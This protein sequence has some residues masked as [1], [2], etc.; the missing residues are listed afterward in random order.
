MG[1]CWRLFIVGCATYSVE[2]RQRSQSVLD[3]DIVLA[4][5]KRYISK[6]DAL[7]TEQSLSLQGSDIQDDVDQIYIAESGMI[8]ELT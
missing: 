5:A 8:F 6:F 2:V 3:R 1:A 7:T 4:H